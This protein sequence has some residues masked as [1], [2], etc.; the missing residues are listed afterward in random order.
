MARRRNDV[1]KR[2]TALASVQGLAQHTRF[3]YCRFLFL[4]N[5]PL[6]ADC[7][8]LKEDGMGESCWHDECA[9][10]A[11]SLPLGSGT[12]ARFCFDGLR[13]QQHRGQDGSGMVIYNTCRA[14]VRKGLGLVPDVYPRAWLDHEA[15]VAI[16][17]NRYATQGSPSAVNLQPHRAI[18][19]RGGRLYLASNGDVT[20][21]SEL[22][23]LLERDGV[24]FQSR[25][26]G[27]LLAWLIARAYDETG[28]MPVAL[29]SLRS[30]VRGAYSA[31]VL[32]QRRVF[33]TRDVL[34]FRPLSMARLPTG[35]HV[36]ASET[37]AF[38]I[39]GAEISSY[40]E[41]PAGSILE[42]AGGDVIVHDPGWEAV[43]PCKFE[44]VYFSRPDSQVFGLPCSLVRRRIG[45]QLARESR[46]RSRKN[47]VVL[48]VPD[49]A[50]W[51]GQG[52]AEALGV[53]FLLGGLVRSH[54]AGEPSSRRNSA[55]ETR[56]FDTNS[57]PIECGWTERS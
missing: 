44:Q 10:M 43:T 51:I 1:A 29:R 5:T 3:W 55:C 31:V 15:E 35:G 25:N 39:L 53:P 54:T 27:E 19:K 9:V 14:L 33:V 23:R 37:I 11:V 18:T 7:F 46:F 26:D 30:T 57:T 49:S 45:W 6:W 8:S 40:Q 20:N 34:G 32:F 13:Q 16:G 28:S 24:V 17:H 2:S 52:V 4:S 47:V 56:G 41:V 48:A 42:L 38:D 36:V 21:F 50:N 12:A 22:R